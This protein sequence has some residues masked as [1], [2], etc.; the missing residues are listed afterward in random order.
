MK[1]L[2]VKETPQSSSKEK[3]KQK[4]DAPG[5]SEVERVSRV[6]TRGQLSKEKGTSIAVEE[7]PMSKAS[8]TDLLEAIE[9]EQDQS[10]QIEPIE[11]EQD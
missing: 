6:K 8:L 1:P 5:P 4:K 10:V 7:S 9:L 11:F 3:V 2:V